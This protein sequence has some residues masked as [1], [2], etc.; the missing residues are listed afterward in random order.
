MWLK[1]TLTLA[2]TTVI[3]TGCAKVEGS[4][5][6]MPGTEVLAYVPDRKPVVGALRDAGIGQPAPDFSYLDSYGQSKS[7]SDWRGKPVLI[8]FW[9]SWCPPCRAEMP[10]LQAIYQDQAPRDN[11]VQFLSV[12]IDEDPSQ[13]RGFMTENG[14]TFPF[15]LDINK[16]V[17]Y[18]YNVYGIPTT[19]LIDANGVIKARKVGAF[20]DKT[21]LETL[22][23]GYRGQ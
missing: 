4:T 7:L 11:G 10:L 17:A 21:E 23:V 1:I 13:A 6:S 2:L 15:L 9:A 19:F 16:S 22:I 3:L 14:Y 8:N 12:S 20:P 5:A 18:A